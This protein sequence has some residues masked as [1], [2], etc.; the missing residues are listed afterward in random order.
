MAVVAVMEVDMEV[1]QEVAIKPLNNLGLLHGIIL[2]LPPPTIS[3]TYVVSLTPSLLSQLSFY[4]TN[5]YRH[6]LA[7]V[8]VE[9]GEV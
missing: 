6:C 2:F 3:N 9:C 8:V 4:H 1:D 5:Y 7:L